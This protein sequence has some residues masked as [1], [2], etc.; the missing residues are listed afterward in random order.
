MQGV[1]AKMAGRVMMEI[2]RQQ[3]DQSQKDNSAGGNAML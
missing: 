2:E 3:K 1:L